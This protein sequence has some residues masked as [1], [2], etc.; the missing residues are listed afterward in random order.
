MRLESLSYVQGMYLC[1]VAITKSWPVVP[2]EVLTIVDNS[3]MPPCHAST[4]RKRR[5]S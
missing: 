2:T 3:R 5:S 1:L 4:D